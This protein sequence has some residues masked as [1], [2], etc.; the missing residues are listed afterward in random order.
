MFQSDGCSSQLQRSPEE[1]G[2]YCGDRSVA[3][4]GN[5]G[6]RECGDRAGLQGSKK[7]YD[8]FF[9]SKKLA[10]FLNR[11]TGCF[12]LTFFASFAQFFH[13]N[14]FQRP[15]RKTSAGT[16]GQLTMSSSSN[17]PD[18]S[19]LM[20]AVA[21]C[22]RGFHPSSGSLLP[23]N[24]YRK[25]K[26]ICSD[27]WDSHKGLC[28]TDAPLASASDAPPRRSATCTQCTLFK[29]QHL[30]WCKRKKKTGSLVL[31]GVDSGGRLKKKNN[32][33]GFNS[34]EDMVK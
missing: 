31:Q 4:K 13:V 28:S 11:L 14:N 15:A 33:R 5:Y 30:I 6:I 32:P 18:S 8:M 22:L 29:C 9:S 7:F 19:S 26:S 1:G 20:T 27:V 2:R 3:L 21:K 23:H 24:D 17:C 10:F 25:K 16:Q 12:S 34:R